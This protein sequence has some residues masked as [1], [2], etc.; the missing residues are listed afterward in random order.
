MIIDDL[1]KLYKNELTMSSQVYRHNYILKN[2][3]II[4]AFFLYIFFWYLLISLDNI[5]FMFVALGCFI[6]FYLLNLRLNSLTVKKRHKDK[7]ISI[8]IWNISMFKEEFEKK[9]AENIIKYND[10]KLVLIQEELTKKSNE[11]K[12]PYIIT[13]SFITILFTP[14]WTFYIEKTLSLFEKSFIKLS[15]TS[16]GF[17]FF[18]IFLAFIRFTLCDF[19]D[20]IIKN[21]YYNCKRL[22]NMISDYR[23]KNNVG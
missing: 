22:N 2:I 7:Y 4:L 23:I 18:I 6:V 8:F 19:K 21:D 11:L 1:L 9:L 13:L 5:V 10:Q 14:L 16:L 3:C 12:A 20:V 15:L 17:F